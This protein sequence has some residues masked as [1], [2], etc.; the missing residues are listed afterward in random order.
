MFD[1]CYVEVSDVSILK[2]Y[3]IP[4]WASQ[5]WPVLLHAASQVWYLYTIIEKKKQNI[6]NKKTYNKYKLVNGIYFYIGNKEV[7]SVMITIKRG[8]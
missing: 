4:A 6:T 5:C 2:C 3:A 7:A 1:I 8:G